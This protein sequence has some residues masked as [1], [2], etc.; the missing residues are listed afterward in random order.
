MNDALRLAGFAVTAA[1]MAFTLRAAHREAGA[2]VRELGGR[3]EAA[4]TGEGAAVR[5]DAGE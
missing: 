1:M 2:A 5:D 4:W 3:A